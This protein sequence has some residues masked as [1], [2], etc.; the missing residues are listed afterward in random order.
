MGEYYFQLAENLLATSKIKD[1]TDRYHVGDV[2]SFTDFSFATYAF[3]NS[4]ANTLYV[5]FTLDK[6]IADSV[7]GVVVNAFKPNVMSG[8]RVLD[9]TDM[10]TSPYSVLAEILRNRSVLRVK[11]TVPSSASL[12]GLSTYLLFFANISMTFN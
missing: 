5:Y 9:Y 8:G 10:T 3:T 4:S 7:S 11:V 1:N 2:Y 12:T 6:P